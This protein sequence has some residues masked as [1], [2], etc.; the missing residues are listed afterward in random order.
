[1]WWQISDRSHYLLKEC[2]IMAKLLC[3]AS[4]LRTD[5][6]RL[7]RLPVASRFCPLCDHSAMDDTFHMVMQCPFLQ[8]SR[9]RMFHEIERMCDDCEHEQINVNNDIFL[10]L[11]GKPA[12]N[13]SIELMIAI[14]E[15][16]ARHITNMYLCKLRTGIG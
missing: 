9:T 14:W 10:T 13:F 11:M 2:E 8:D 3:H 4:L 15:C 16:S 5:D 12:A 7:K 6:V 1:M